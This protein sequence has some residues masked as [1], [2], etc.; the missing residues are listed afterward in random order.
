MQQSLDLGGSDWVDHQPAVPT[1]RSAIIQSEVCKGLARKS[2]GIRGVEQSVPANLIMVRRE[3]CAVDPLV[4]A[5]DVLVSRG[6]AS[7]LIVSGGSNWWATERCPA[8]L[9]A[10]R[11]LDEQSARVPR[12]S[13]LGTVALT[14]YHDPCADRWR[15]RPPPYHRMTHLEVAA[16]SIA[17]PRL[18]E[19]PSLAEGDSKCW[20][21]VLDLSR[22]FRVALPI[23]PAERSLGRRSASSVTP[24]WACR[25]R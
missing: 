12:S 21:R 4:Q 24:P 6:R 18:R 23:I 11:S 16:A 7:G 19:R 25:I 2:A 1:P 22:L 17:S 20:Y 5:H 8:P 3:A 9:N 13:P 10:A 14:C 15:V